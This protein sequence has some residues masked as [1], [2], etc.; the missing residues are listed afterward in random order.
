SSAAVRAT[1]VASAGCADVADFRIPAHCAGLEKL[2]HRLS[3]KRLGEE[4]TLGHVATT[5]TQEIELLDGLDPFSHD[6]FSQGVRHHDDGLDQGGGSGVLRYFLEESAIDL[7]RSDR[8]LPQV[9]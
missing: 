6:P 2:C 8:I 9:R 3:G 1:R 5:F 4:E 7:H